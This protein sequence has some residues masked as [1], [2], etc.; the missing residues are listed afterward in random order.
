[1]SRVLVAYASKHGATAEIAEA[2]ADQLRQV[3]HGVDCSPA[4]SS[5]P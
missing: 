3:G 1:M 5:V 2:V 4:E